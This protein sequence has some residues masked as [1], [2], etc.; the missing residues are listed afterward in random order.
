MTANAAGDQR[1]RRRVTTPVATAV[2]ATGTYTAGNANA[3]W[4]N[5]HYITI[6]INGGATA[7]TLSVR[8]E[9]AGVNTQPGALGYA[10]IGI[11]AVNLATATNLQFAVTGFFDAFA[12]VITGAVTGGTAPSVT[13]VV[14]STLIE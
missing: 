6:L 7:G 9:P 4:A 12:V 3:Q 2:A 13:V 5:N 14:N 8:G 1:I 11:E 10:K